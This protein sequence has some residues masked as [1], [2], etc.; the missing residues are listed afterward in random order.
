MKVGWGNK[1]LRRQESTFDFLNE[2]FKCHDYKIISIWNNE[3]NAIVINRNYNWTYEPNLMNL[4]H[5]K[6]NKFS[7][8]KDVEMIT[9]IDKMFNYYQDLHL[10]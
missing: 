2:R 10:D 4:V 8:E 1:F 5:I 6:G 3:S 9:E 7:K